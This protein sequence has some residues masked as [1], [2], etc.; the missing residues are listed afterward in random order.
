MAK[1]IRRWFK[2]A[3]AAANAK[4]EEKADPKIQLQQ[5]I[6]EAQRQH[7]LLSRQAAAVIGNQHQLEMKLARQSEEVARLQESARQ[8]L[9]LSDQAAAA[10]DT[11]K[12]ASYQ[13]A[14]QTF[15]SQL[16]SAEAA[17]QDLAHLHEQAASSAAAARQ[18]VE[19]NSMVLQRK[20]AE[21]S[22]LLTQLEQAKMQ[23]QIASAMSSVSE[24][25][26]PTDVPTLTTVRDKIEQRYATAMGST[27]LASSSVEA[28]MLEVQSASID[29]AA[30]SRL[31]QIRASLT[32]GSPGGSPSGPAA[33]TTAA[34]PAI[35][36]A[37]AAD[38]EQVQ[39]GGGATSA[40]SPAPGQEAPA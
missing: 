26:A 10:G 1:V 22:K 37:V 23:E 28:R 29:A 3:G 5:A 4:L 13:Q 33:V 2:Y 32:S 19:Q 17:V 15:A 31:E 8:A 35:A 25:A 9:M 6:E 39:P 30:A 7:A 16:V 27:E 24:L 38:A 34:T 18:A 14:A 40:D 12:A 11:A 21:R 20:L 36:G